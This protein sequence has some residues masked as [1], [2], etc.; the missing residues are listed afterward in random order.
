MFA[1]RIAPT[2]H[3]IIMIN[4]VTK[5]RNSMKSRYPLVDLV[6]PL[7]VVAGVGGQFVI[8]CSSIERCSLSPLASR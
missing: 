1:A 4:G 7:G 6:A 2:I 3:T 5:S 8:G